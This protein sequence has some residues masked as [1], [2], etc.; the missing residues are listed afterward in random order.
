MVMRAE[1]EINELKNGRSQIVVSELP[2]QV[3]KASL[4][5]RIAQMTRDKKIDGISGYS[6]RVG[7]E[8]A[9]ASYWT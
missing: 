2:Y 9:S 6:G 8:G 5:A 1:V 3:N 4:V 7:Q